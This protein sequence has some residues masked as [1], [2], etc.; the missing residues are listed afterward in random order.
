MSRIPKKPQRI[1]DNSKLAPKNPQ[2]S[3]RISKK[4]SENLKKTSKNLQT[5][6]RICDNLNPAPKNLQESQRISKINFLKE[7]VPS[8]KILYGLHAEKPKKS[9][10]SRRIP[11]NP[12]E[13]RRISKN[14]EES[15]ESHPWKKPQ[16]CFFS[17]MIYVAATA[18][19]DAADASDAAA[20]TNQMNHFITSVVNSCSTMSIQSNY[21]EYVNSIKCDSDRSITRC[22]VSTF[23]SITTHATP[24]STISLHQSTC[25]LSIYYLL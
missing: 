23:K 16:R 25:E 19:A 9:R 22:Q 2:E 6:R 11:K 8:F 7:P 21:I 14:P 3:Q 17:L 24:L 18:A 5:E 20:R 10:A 1:C 15:R 4:T 12:E 13:S